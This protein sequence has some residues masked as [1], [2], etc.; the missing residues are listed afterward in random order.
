MPRLTEEEIDSIMYLVRKYSDLWIKSE[1]YTKRLEELTKDRESLVIEIE[2]LSADMDVSK[3][4]EE[5]LDNKLKNRYGNI[6]LD[7]ET[8]EYTVIE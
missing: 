2:K 6:H 1:E 5:I 3:Q 7:M 4:E 8:F